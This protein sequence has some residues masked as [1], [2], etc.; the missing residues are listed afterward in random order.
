MAERCRQVGDRVGVEEP[1]HVAG[2]FAQEP[3]RGREA[4]TQLVG[5]RNQERSRP[6]HVHTDLAVVGWIEGGNIDRVR[7]LCKELGGGR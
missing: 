6:C 5:L 1:V 3:L 2:V 4:L 7:L